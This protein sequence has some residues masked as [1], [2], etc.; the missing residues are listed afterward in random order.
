MMTERQQI[1]HFYPVL[2]VGA[3]V[4]PRHTRKEVI[5]GKWVSSIFTLNK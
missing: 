2:R 3:E 1:A 4:H 5:F